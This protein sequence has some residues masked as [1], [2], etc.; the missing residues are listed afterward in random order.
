MMVFLAGRRGS[1]KTTLAHQ[2]ETVGYLRVHPASIAENLRLPKDELGVF[3]GLT[4]H[5]RKEL[6]RLT[7]DIV[8]DGSPRTAQQAVLT[9]EI[10]A[11]ERCTVLVL[12]VTEELSSRRM[13]ERG[14]DDLV[15][16]RAHRRWVEVERPALEA[17]SFHTIDA[18]LAPEIVFKQALQLIRGAET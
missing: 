7:G 6:D 4:E 1:G 13:R 8:V 17:V 12:D 18:T 15:I 3:I 14:N 10:A 11:R 5:L 2:L 9:M 16:Q